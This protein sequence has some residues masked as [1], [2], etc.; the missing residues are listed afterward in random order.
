MLRQLYNKE[1]PLPEYF[2]KASKQQQR[3]TLEERNKDFW[4]NWIGVEH[5]K[6]DGHHLYARID[7]GSLEVVEAEWRENPKPRITKKKS[8]AN[9]NIQQIKQTLDLLEVAQHYGIELHKQGRYTMICCP[10]P[11]HEDNNPSCVINGREARSYANTFKCFSCGVRGDIIDFAALME[12][13]A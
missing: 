2:S 1:N 8:N 12:A 13:K 10:H 6:P 9:N 5:P 7:R 4:E 11:D 3:E